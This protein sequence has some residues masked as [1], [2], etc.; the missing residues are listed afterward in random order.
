MP[1]M[2]NQHPVRIQSAL[3]LPLLGSIKAGYPVMADT[4]NDEHVSLDRYL[5][6]HPGFT[7]LLKVSGDSMI[8]EGI[9]NGDLVI[10]DKLREPKHK[11]IVAALIDGEWTLKYFRKEKGIV[12]LQAANPK[13]PDIY[14]KEHLTIGGVV[15]SVIKKYY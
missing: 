13:Y 5:V 11:D 6:P 9:N 1:S 2:I 7:F 4:L 12:Y 8:N 14:P 10:L 15:V 3:T